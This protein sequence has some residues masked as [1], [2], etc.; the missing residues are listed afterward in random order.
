M[1][2]RARAGARA[3]S[4]AIRCWPSTLRADRRG[5]PRRVLQG[6]IAQRIE[7]YM[8]ANGGYL[9]AAD[10]AA[11][12][13][14][15]VEPVSTN[16][17]G[18]DVWELP[19]NRPGHRRAADAQHPRGLRPEVDGLRQPRLP[20]P[21][22]RGQEAGLRRP[23][24]LLRRPRVREAPARRAALEGVRGQAPQADRPRQ[25]ALDVSRR[26]PNARAG[27]HHL[28]DRG[29]QGPQHGLADPEQLPRLRLGHDARRL[30]LR[31]AEPRRAVRPRRTAT[32]N[33]YAP[34]KRP[35]HTI[36]PAF[37]T[38]GRQAVAV[39]SASWAAT[40]SRRATCRSS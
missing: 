29:R 8:R 4:S 30:R 24:A 2:G 11:H 40:C 15:W 20:A 1:P 3:R 21:V 7:T 26:Q 12:R 16:Y 39:A 25:A 18:Y 6:D 5:R 34:G 31:P 13:S 9:T 35:F 38:E 23:R 37:V 33:V 27:R 22:R 10:L 36:I 32:P 14:E 28:P 17:R 19:P